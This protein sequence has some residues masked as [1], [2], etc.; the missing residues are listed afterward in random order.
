MRF[1]PTGVDGCR[2]RLHNA[3]YH[4]SCYSRRVDHPDREGTDWVRTKPD[5]GPTRALA[6]IVG[7]SDHVGSVMKKSIRRVVCLRPTGFSPRLANVLSPP[8]PRAWARAQRCRVVNYSG[9]SSGRRPERNMTDL[10]PRPFVG[11]KTTGRD[12]CSR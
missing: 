11:R 3:V 6:P 4:N 10:V 12:A 7:S 9:S 8:G 2:R 1:I 5:Q